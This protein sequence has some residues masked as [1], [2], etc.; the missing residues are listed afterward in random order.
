MGLKRKPLATVGAT[1]SLYFNSLSYTLM[2][3]VELIHCFTFLGQVQK[4]LRG[5]NDK[6]AKEELLKSVTRGVGK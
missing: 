3:G 4:M 6:E 1:L 5:S 2:V